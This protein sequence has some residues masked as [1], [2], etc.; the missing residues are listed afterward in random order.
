ME[1]AQFALWSDGSFLGSWG[2]CGNVQVMGGRDG[3][4]G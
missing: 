4:G 3:K 1:T 2:G